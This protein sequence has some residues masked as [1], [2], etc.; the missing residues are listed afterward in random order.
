MFQEEQLRESACDGDIERV[1]RLIQQGVS[2]NSKHN[3]NGWTPLHWACKR[4]HQSIV[5]LLLMNGAERNVTNNKGELPVELTD[6]LQI[7]E[8]LGASSDTQYK[9]EDLPIT[10]NYI[11]HPKFPYIKS[12]STPA[13]MNG[14]AAPAE[15]DEMLRSKMSSVAVPSPSLMQP[16]YLLHKEG[17]LDEK[18]LVLKVRIALA[19]ETDFIEIELDR[20]KLTYE[21]L[22]LTC[23]RELEVDRH[24]AY[25]IRKMPNTIL[26]KDKDVRRLL[27]FQQIELI[28][29]SQAT[30]AISRHYGGSQGGKQIISPAKDFKPIVY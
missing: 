1:Q 26:R 23:C 13:N 14:Y 25:R 18:E 11:S 22:L 8:I 10:P 24:L 21:N 16:N 12:S 20:N 3:I 19:A 17:I 30:S 29:T 5:S 15:K 9:C 7:R 6:K 2:V 27:D 4:G 28:L